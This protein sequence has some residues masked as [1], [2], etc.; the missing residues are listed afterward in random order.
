[1]SKHTPGPWVSGLRADGGRINVYA[2]D[3]M[4]TRICRVETGA[5]DARIVAAAPDLLAA[6]IAVV[7]VAD[8]TTVEFDAARA[9]IAKARGGES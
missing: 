8:R 6:L 4:A 3:T 1:M 7:R 9:A 5:E 2:D